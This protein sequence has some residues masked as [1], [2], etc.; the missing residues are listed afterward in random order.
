MVEIRYPERRQHLKP[1]TSEGR[2]V[3][4]EGERAP[5]AEYLSMKE[6]GRQQQTEEIFLIVS[7]FPVVPNCQGKV[8]RTV[9]L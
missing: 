8:A 9:A 6:R 1:C 2:V 3:L 4:G 5:E 7:N